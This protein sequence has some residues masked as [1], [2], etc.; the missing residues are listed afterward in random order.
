MATIEA[1]LPWIPLFP[2]IGFLA[3]GLCAR[4]SSEGLVSFLGCAG[5]FLSFCYAGAAF[6]SLTEL[7]PAQRHVTSVLYTWI[8]AGDFSARFALTLDPL[9]AVMALVVSG[10][11]FLIHV[12]SVGY[13]HGDK[14]FGRY[15]SY[16]N[17][18]L[19]SMLLLVLGDNLVLMFVGWEGVGLCSYLLIGFWFEEEANASAGKKA[20]IV[21]RVGDLGFLLGIFLTWLTF[22]S[23]D[24]AQ[25]TKGD[26]TPSQLEAVPWIALFLFIGATGKSA[27]IPLHVWLPDAMAGPTPVSA[28][29][30]AATMVTAGVY[31]VTRMGVFYEHAP[32]VAGIVA[33]IGALTAL[34][35]GLIA[36]AQNDIKKVLAYSTISQL[37]YMFLAAGSLAFGAAIFHLVT[38]AFF[39]ALLFLAAGAVIHALGGEQDIRKMGGLGSKLRFTALVTGIGAV[40]LMGIPP[41]AG[42]MSKDAIL[43]GVFERFHATHNPLWIVLYGLGL[44][45]ALATA[46]YVT[47]WYVLIFLAKPHEHGEEGHAHPHPPGRAMCFALGTLAVLT[48]AGGWLSPPAFLG[49]TDR[50][51]RFLSPSIVASHGEGASH[52]MEVVSSLLALGAALAGAFVGWTMYFKRPGASKVFVEQNAFGKKAYPVVLGKFYFDEAYDAVFVRGV[53]RLALFL[54]IIVDMVFIE[55]FVN[56]M[57]FLAGGLS[58]AARRLQTGKIP[59]YATTL[60][61]ATV[62]IVMFLLLRGW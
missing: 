52:A 38:H 47:R 39:K 27:Q 26:F 55:M 3:N 14:G 35:A 61:V 50:L 58:L 62:A 57:A 60:A 5:P 9:S 32:V 23:V 20:F 43:W 10:V 11:G 13:M 8:S 37:G 54:W 49:V 59:A 42:F 53:K 28:L 21:N 18:F 56:G 2:L 7:D 22:N 36:F 48:I 15:F 12:Y 4:R 1:L 40:A 33:T 25:L 41:F 51:G 30:H 31:M 34:M 29:I 44:L 24:F 46:F 16:L 45:G 6:L 17:L 19:S